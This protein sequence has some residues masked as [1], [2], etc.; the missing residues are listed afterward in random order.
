M[1]MDTKLYYDIKNQGLLIISDFEEKQKLMDLG[2]DPKIEYKKINASEIINYKIKNVGFDRIQNELFQFIKDIFLGLKLKTV[3]FHE[4]SVDLSDTIIDV[5]HLLIGEKSKIEISSKNFKYLEEI[6]FLS[7]KSFKGKVLDKF[8]AVK[9]AVLWDSTKIFTLPE[10]FPNLKELTIN[11]GSLTELDLSNHEDLEK[12]DVHYC[13]KLER[14]L[15]SNNHRLNDIFIEN[16]KNL[17]ITNLPSLAR[18]WPQRK[19]NIDKKLLI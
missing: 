4:S 8:D 19:V 11:K 9:K 1:K 2:V 7:L 12:L 14:I 3:V 16:C 17:D 10:M 15:V 6:T 18:I 13:S 5:Q